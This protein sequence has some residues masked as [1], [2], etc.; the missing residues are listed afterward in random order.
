MSIFFVNFLSEGYCIDKLVR[1]IFLIYFYNSDVRWR[2]AKHSPAWEEYILK[3]NNAQ[4][5][6]CD[7]ILKYNSSKISMYHIGTSE[8]GLQCKLKMKCCPPTKVLH[9]CWIEDAVVK[10]EQMQ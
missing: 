7:I 3:E 1:L 2:E 6:Y 10:S 8:E 5:K 9:R 4:C